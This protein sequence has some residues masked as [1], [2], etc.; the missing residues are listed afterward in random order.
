MLTALFHWCI[1]G[2]NNRGA[3]GKIAFKQQNWLF[4]VED[5]KDIEILTGFFY[6]QQ[7]HPSG[8]SENV[9]NKELFVE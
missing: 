5:R 3:E 6:A 1:V 9:R 8:I 4:A 7:T 2:I